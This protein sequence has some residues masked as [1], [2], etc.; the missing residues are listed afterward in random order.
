MSVSHD[1]TPAKVPITLEGLVAEIERLRAELAAAKEPA[2]PK[3]SR[4]TISGLITFAVGA[5]VGRV[6]TKMVDAEFGEGIGDTIK[7]L[8]LVFAA[9]GGSLPIPDA[10]AKLFGVGAAKVVTALVIGGTLTASSLAIPG[11]ASTSIDYGAPV[12]V[13]WQ[14]NPCHIRVLDRATLEEVGSISAPD[15][16][17][18]EPDQS[19]EVEV[20]P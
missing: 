2:K 20:S 17:P 18:A 3:L 1:V 19:L 7:A 16:C 10:L 11:C 12:D 14:Q 6:L 5:V 9:F 15:S 4:L 13:R 8:G